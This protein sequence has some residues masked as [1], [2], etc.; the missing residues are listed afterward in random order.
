LKGGFSKDSTNIHVDKELSGEKMRDLEQTPLQNRRVVEHYAAHLV[1][2]MVTA[3][4]VYAG[5]GTV[6]VSAGAVLNRQTI[7]KLNKWAVAKVPVLVE[8]GA[9]PLQDPKIRQFMHNYQTSVHAV[10]RAF[11]MIRADGEVPLQTFEAAADRITEDVLSTGNAVDQLYNLPPCDDYT[12]RHCVNV[13]VVSAMIAMWLKY[14]ADIINAISLAGLMHDIGKSKLP[15]ELLHKPFRL[16]PAKYELYKEHTSL[17]AELLKGRPDIGESVIAGVLEHH[18]RCDG[19][20]YPARLRAED[21]HPYAK[22]IAIAD[23]YDEELTINLNPEVVV[24]PYTSL[25][26]VWDEV[27]RFDAKGCVTFMDNMTNFLSGNMV[28]LSDKRQGR[29]VCINKEWPSRSMVQMENGEVLDLMDDGSPRIQ[30]L[31]R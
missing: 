29:V 13:S 28:A 5:D 12:F 7:E 9:S 30:Y 2:G 20:G 8:A 21:I 14:P 11:D 23:R 22:I 4:D 31:V 6:L 15:S 17:G 1:S 27:R 10:E 26:K 25:E 24:S 18:E 19:S 16:P 3:K